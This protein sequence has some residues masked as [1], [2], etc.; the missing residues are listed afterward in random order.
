M[1]TAIIY[2]NPDLFIVCLLIYITH[3]RT[4]TFEI[5]K[6]AFTTTTRA[7]TSKM[8]LWKLF[9]SPDLRWSEAGNPGWL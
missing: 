7:A 1:K 8:N 6:L 3:T 5:K 4:H 2:N 9:H